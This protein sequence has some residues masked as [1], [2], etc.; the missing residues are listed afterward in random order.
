LKTPIQ[1]PKNSFKKNGLP[2]AGCAEIIGQSAELAQ[3]FQRAEQVASLDAPVLLLGEPGTGKGM[4]ARLI[5]Q[6]SARKN[7]PMITLNC[8]ALPAD[9]IDRE[10]FGEE[11]AGGTRVDNRQIG[12]FELAAGGSL[13]LDEIGNLS[14]E[15]QSKLRRVIQDG[16]FERLGSP[17]TIKTDVRIIA[18]TNRNLQEEIHNGRFQHDLYSRLNVFPITLPPLRERKAD[19]PLL[20]NHFLGIFNRKLGK[21]I[22]TLSKMTLNT[23]QEYPWPGN[24]WELESLIERAVIISQGS[25]LQTLNCFE[26]DRLPEEV[27]GHGVVALVDLE[28]DYVLQVLQNAGWRIDGKS[29]AALLLGL[30]PSTLRARMRKLGIVRP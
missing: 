11:K 13:F 30:N 23:L 29:G 4:L 22:K 1:R 16:E 25:T 8:A 20:V 17:R 18:A 26:K 12:R 15:L 5:H 24:L 9:R 2:Q 10:L 21:K 14:L 27:V 28:H 6:R 3:V 7:K 19:I